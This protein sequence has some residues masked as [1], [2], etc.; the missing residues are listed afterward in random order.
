MTRYLRLYLNEADTAPPCWSHRPGPPS[1]SGQAFPPVWTAS[2]T[3]WA[4]T[5]DSS[6]ASDGLPRRQR[7]RL[8][9]KRRACPRPRM[10]RR[11]DGERR[12]LPDEFFGSRRMTLIASGV[13]DMLLG[14][15]PPAPTS[16]STR[17]GWSTGSSSG[18]L[19]CRSAGWPAAC[20]SY[21]GGAPPRRN[22]EGNR[23]DRA[24]R[25]PAAPGELE[26]GTHRAGRTATDH[27]RAAAGRP[28]RTAR[29]RLPA[30]RQRRPRLRLGLVRVIWAIRTLRTPP[31]F[32]N[33]QCPTPYPAC[34]KRWSGRQRGLKR[35]RPLSAVFICPLL[36]GRHA[37]H[38]GNLFLY[39]RIRVERCCRG[40]STTCAPRFRCRYCARKTGAM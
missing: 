32:K 29:P 8:T 28:G 19:H 38:C 40:G 4:G 27:Q 26:L 16:S 10:G 12:E 21:A 13:T 30:G 35:R 18:S 2:P 11:G 7:L 25:G 15:E 36:P 6:T 5:C 34:P 22:A 31:R 37:R 14:K 1:C 33:I 20:R 9:R 24:P 23:A 3:R 17:C 39:R